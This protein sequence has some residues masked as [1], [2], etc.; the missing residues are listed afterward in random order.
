MTEFRQISLGVLQGSGVSPVVLVACRS[1]Q[2]VFPYPQTHQ[3]DYSNHICPWSTPVE[4]TSQILSKLPRQYSWLLPSRTFEQ[5]T[6]SSTTVKS[7]LKFQS[8]NPT[9]VLPS[10]TC[11]TE[12]SH[13]LRYPSITVDS[14]MPAAASR[15]RLP[16]RTPRWWRGKR[17]RLSYRNTATITCPWHCSTPGNCP[18]S[19]STRSPAARSVAGSAAGIAAWKFE[20]W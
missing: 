15:P 12:N 20:A 9:V 2:L 5:S 17:N 18:G 16:C 3:P 6:G 14:R 8:I 1:M 11:P 7:S 19:T 4:H 13:L 10:R